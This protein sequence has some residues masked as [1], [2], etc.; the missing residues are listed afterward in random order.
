MNQEVTPVMLAAVLVAVTVAVHGSGFALVLRYSM[1]SHAVPSLNRR[2]AEAN[3]A[4][5]G[6]RLNQPDWSDHSHSLAFTAEIAKDK[7]LFHPI[8][9]SYW[10]PL[11]FELPPAGGEAP[12][13]WRRWIDSA[14]D[15]PNDIVPWR[16]APAPSVPGTTYHAEARS[17]VALYAPARGG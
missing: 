6:V 9:N 5:H 16:D 8:L 10:E 11:D 7:L 13:P 12:N 15:S 14:L 4:W 1:K 17:I 3:K 2:F